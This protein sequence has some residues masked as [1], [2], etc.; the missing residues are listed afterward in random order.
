M[1]HFILSV[2]LLLSVI[3]CVEHTQKSQVIVTIKPIYALVSGVMEG[4]GTPYLLLHGG[5]SPH[6]YTLR[7]SQVRQLH[8]ASLIVWVGPTV[9]AFLE[10]TLTTVNKPLLRLIDIPDLTLLKTHHDD[11]DFNP[12]IWLDPHN[13][14]IMVTAIATAL[15]QNDPH[16]ANRY[17]ANAQNLITQLKQLDHHIKAQLNSIK[18]IPYMVF[19]DAY[20]YFEHRY[21]LKSVGTISISPESR[22]SVKHL[23]ELRERLKKKDVRCVFTEPQFE[24]SLVASLIENTTVRQG[25]LDPLGTNNYFTLLSNL[26]DS[27]KACLLSDAEDGKP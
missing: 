6:N 14:M 16:N 25:I 19:H 15:S 26:A 21:G 24:S 5:E 8:A 1:K 11:H 7:P 18:D 27:L 2:S 17:H 10:K 13:A 22:P 20:Q 12:H 9:E 23:Y 4:V 3:G